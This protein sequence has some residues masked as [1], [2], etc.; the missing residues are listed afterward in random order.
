MIF[1]TVTETWF[2]YIGIIVLTILLIAGILY[3]TCGLRFKREKNNKIEHVLVDEVFLNDLIIGLGN[4]ENILSVTIDNGRLKFKVNNLE[5]LD[6]DILKK[7][8]SSGVF[9]TGSNVKLLFKY[10]STVILEEL[11]RRGIR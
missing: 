10:D 2:L 8:S 4:E 1:L 11:N 7:L 6:T 9:I 3:F 5:L